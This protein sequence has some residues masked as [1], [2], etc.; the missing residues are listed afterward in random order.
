M[1]WLMGGFQL[2]S[3]ETLKLNHFK[4]EFV[5]VGIYREVKLS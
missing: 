3:Q 2:L 5:G 1:G 4:L